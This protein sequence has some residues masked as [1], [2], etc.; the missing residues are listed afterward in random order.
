MPPFSLRVRPR[1]GSAGERVFA[2]ESARLWSAAFARHGA[3]WAVIFACITDA[4]QPV[5]VLAIGEDARPAE[6]TEAILR[7][8][9]VRAPRMG[10]LI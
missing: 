5:R 9:L 3:E 1:R 4:R 6:L 2:D 10:P 8:W 7:E